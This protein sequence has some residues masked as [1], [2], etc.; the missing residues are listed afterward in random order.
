MEADKDLIGLRRR[1]AALT[2]EARK[3]EDAWQRSH[4]REMD[5]LEAD[6]LGTLLERL[7]DRF[8][9]QLSAGRGDPGACRSR[10]RDS[11]SADDP[12]PPAGTIS[13]GPVRRFGARYP[14]ADRDRAAALARPIFPCRSRCCCFPPTPT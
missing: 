8:A 12:G 9:R 3:N 2:E 7:T 6:T 5:L 1:I 14:A 13:G 11:A 10:P 4:R